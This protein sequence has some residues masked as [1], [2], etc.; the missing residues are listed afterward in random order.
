MNSRNVRFAL[1]ALAAFGAFTIARLG[2]NV[3]RYDPTADLLRTVQT[4]A[5]A[6]ASN[7][8]PLNYGP[9]G[10]YTRSS[11]IW[12]SVPAEN[13]QSAQSGA[14]DAK[15]QARVLHR[16]QS[17]SGGTEYAALQIRIS[18]QK[19]ENMLSSMRAAFDV[20]RYEENRADKNEQFSTLQ[21]RLE[22][23]QQTK[24]RITITPEQFKLSASR[25]L[26]G[27]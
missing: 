25:E 5:L 8:V 18:E 11:S 9:E 21:A 3:Y 26:S 16:K 15:D 20:L 14:L 27:R 19:A 10:Y 6:G 1:L 23:L 17:R 4:E 7:E 2:Y 12:L 24:T 13:F 22:A